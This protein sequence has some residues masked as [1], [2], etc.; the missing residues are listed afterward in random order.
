[1]LPLLSTLP[2]AQA[3]V[4]LSPSSILGTHDSY[5]GMFP[6]EEII[7]GEGLDTA[8]VSGVTGFDD[9]INRGPR[10]WDSAG[11]FS[12]E[13]PHLSYIIDFD[14]GATYYLHHVVIWLYNME[15]D[16]TGYSANAFSFRISDQQD[17]SSS[18]LLGSF[19]IA[20][21][22]PDAHVFSPN[23][24]VAG[25]YLRME[26]LNN[27]EQDLDIVGINEIAVGV[28]TVP[29][30]SASLLVM[31]SLALGMTALRRRETS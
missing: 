14:L 21:N 15:G 24:A 5:Y 26:I 18:T 17:F 12:P 1:M 28:A 29:E 16:T 25:R 13:E 20:E 22:T 6:I 10:T 2:Q 27:F 8:F 31:G 7:D 11:W 9:F 23:E 30:P 4:I 3:A 19:G